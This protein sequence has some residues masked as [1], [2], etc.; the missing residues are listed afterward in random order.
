MTLLDEMISDALGATEYEALE[1]RLS[2]KQA[3]ND[4]DKEPVVDN[5]NNN[6]NT[7]TAVKA[8]RRG[9]GKPT[10]QI[11]KGFLLSSSTTAAV[12]KGPSS[13]T[14]CSS[15]TAIT[16]NN[17]NNSSTDPLGRFPNVS[18]AMRD[19][20]NMTT[21]LDQVGKN[22][23][24]A[25]AL[26]DPSFTSAL[27]TLQT[28]PHRAAEIFSNQSPDFCQLLQEFTTLVGT[29]QQQA[30]NVVDTEQDKVNRL[31]GNAAIQEALRDEELQSVLQE[32]LRPGRLQAYMAHPVYGPK[33]RLLMDA[34][35][36]QVQ[37][38]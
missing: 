6:N 19:N 8:R 29:Q 7:E 26:Q 27:Q 37:G 16:A 4:S 11:K 10:R 24:L 20:L 17:N 2:S 30:S 15:T 9:K 22:P 36:F 5:S 35:L 21:L 38:N 18:E 28:E 25:Q 3:P 1:R 33:I 32:C 12:E 14:T 23:R 34:G 13:P 31:L